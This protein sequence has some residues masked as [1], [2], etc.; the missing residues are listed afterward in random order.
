MSINPDFISTFWFLVGV[1]GCGLIL[2]LAIRSAQWWR[3]RDQHDLNVLICTILG[4]FFIWILKAD[5][6]ANQFSFGLNLHLI[7]ATLLTL[8]FGWS[9][10]VLA[11][12]LVIT[13][14]AIIH[15]D[16]GFA[17]AWNVL[18]TGILPISVSYRIFRFAD[19]RLPNNFFIYI[20]ICAF[21]GAALSMASV[22]LGTTAFHSLS[23]SFSLTYLSY[24]YF[25]YGLL[26]MF[27]E[28]FITGMLM[29]I[30]VVY[31]PQW[32]STF[33]DHRYLQKH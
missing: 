25:P 17:L 12:S 6:A 7:G 29:S 4:V 33:D 32:V 24:N 1:L 9:F 23:G 26:L 21:F 18:I 2:Y 5:Y 10:A 8:M 14:I 3:L 15:G 28:A 11:L 22:I 27:P 16:N 13:A 31:R 30:F 19:R 20:F